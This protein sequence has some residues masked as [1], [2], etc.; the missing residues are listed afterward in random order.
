[1]KSEP[2]PAPQAEPAA[3]DED[4]TPELAAGM[5][6]MA[7]RRTTVTVERETVTFLIRRPVVSPA[8][9][10]AEGESVP[11]MPNELS[12]GKP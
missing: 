3:Q 9:R 2:R 7:H 4:T 5:P 8:D 10:P 11:E 12:G 6:P 1:M